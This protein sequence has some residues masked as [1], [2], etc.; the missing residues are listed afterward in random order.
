ME[1]F[2][3]ELWAI[4]LGVDVMI[5]KKETFHKHGLKKVAVLSDSQAS[6]RPT[7][8]LEPGP[9]QHLARRINRR[10]QTPLAHGIAAETHWVPGHYGIT[11]NED[12]DRQV[13]LARAGSGSIVRE[14]AY[15]SASN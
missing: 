4:G 7:A 9:G 13:N 14:R 1:V 11:G 12:T 3:A 2:D 5:E 8:H 10:A 15:S 6:I